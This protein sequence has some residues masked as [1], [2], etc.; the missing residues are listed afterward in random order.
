MPQADG[1]PKT[2]IAIEGFTTPSGHIKNKEDGLG[3]EVVM[4][5][6]NHKHWLE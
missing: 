2:Q 1:T 4:L 6:Q 3:R 5:C